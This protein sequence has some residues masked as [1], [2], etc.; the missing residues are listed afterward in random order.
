MIVGI[1][2]LIV[3]IFEVLLLETTKPTIGRTKKLSEGKD[4][5]E[6]V[7]DVSLN[8]QDKEEFEDV[9]LSVPEEEI[10]SAKKKVISLIE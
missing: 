7:G 9:E 4:E 3:G 1:F 5:D 8:S 2:D 10:E 6:K